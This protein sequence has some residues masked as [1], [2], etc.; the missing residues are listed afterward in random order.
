MPHRRVLA[1]ALAAFTLT[2]TT[3][4]IAQP[5]VVTIDPGE[6]HQTIEGWGTFLGETNAA[7]R[8]AYKN[9][10][11]NIMRMSMPKEV[12]YADPNNLSIRVPLSDDIDAN[13]A[14]MDFDHSAVAGF[15]ATA[16]WMRDNVPDFKL[17]AD[18][19]SPPHWMKGPTGAS[20]QWIGNPVNRWVR[21]YTNNNQWTQITNSP[22]FPTPW[23]SNQY[24]GWQD[25]MNIPANPN[26]EPGNPHFIG[27]SGDSIGGRLRTEDPTTLREFGQYMAAWVKGFESRYGVRI[28]N[29]SLQNEST[30]ENPFDS[31]T[32]IRDQHGNTDFKQYA[33]LLK[34]A[35]DAFEQHGLDTG[36]RGPHVAHLGATASNPFGQ[37]W[38]MEM[39]QGVKEHADPDL[40]DKLTVYTSNYYMGVSETDVRMTAAYWKG[41][42]KVS[43]GPGQSWAS[44]LDPSGIEADGKPN[45]Y[46]ETGDGSSQWLD[47]P[48]QPG[49][50]AIT[51]A[52]KMHNALVH[53]DAA[54]YL[55][56]QFVDGSGNE[57]GVYGLVGPSQ[58]TNPTANKKYDAFGHFSMFVRPGARRIDALFSN[59]QSS[60]RGNSEYDTL[61]SVNVSAYLHEEDATLTIVLLNLTP[62]DEEISIELPELLGI[63]AFTIYRTSGTE[64]LVNLGTFAVDGGVVTFDLPG[65]S[66]V[67]LTGAIPVPEPAAL[68][69][70][71]PALLAI[72]RR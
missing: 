49:T 59:G 69:L 42:D 50:G 18:S 17:I 44:W 70:L 64:N 5:L 57:P 14:L 28:D 25:Y 40:I 63:A 55:Y 72:R 34:S 6:R 66:I 16:A 41:K 10:G 62:E 20:S 37:W 31:M 33:M 43:P 23:F 15:G 19:W 58:V 53:S 56:W 27:Y 47:G 54:A 48:N 1:P 30:F 21:D 38:Q 3:G 11:M 12:L 52:L 29:I 22:A 65:Y 8:Q 36:I 61:H 60:I 4:A 2:A 26:N 24:N 35:A 32:V 51:V 67:T 39:I 9:L 13:V 68:A 46:V 71:L 45:W 7:T